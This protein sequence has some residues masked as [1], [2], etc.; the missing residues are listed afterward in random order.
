MYLLLGT[1]RMLHPVEQLWYPLVFRLYPK[2]GRIRN[3]AK[4]RPQPKSDR[5]RNPADTRP[6]LASGRIRN[7]AG[8]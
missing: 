2:P 4:M 3:L 1:N 5:I 8:L 6:H 7:S